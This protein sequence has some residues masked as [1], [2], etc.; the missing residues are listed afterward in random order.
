[1]ET[2]TKDIG[3]DVIA[4]DETD[5]ENKPKETFNDV[6][7]NEMR[8]ANDQEQGHVRPA[9]L[10]ELELV[11]AFLEVQDEQDKS[12]VVHREGNEAMVRGERQ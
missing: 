11:H 6:V 5:G 3:H 4:N 10:R 2:R 1:M 9:K 12:N 8:L 7:H